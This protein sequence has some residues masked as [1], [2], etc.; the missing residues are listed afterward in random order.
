M[1]EK[2]RWMMIWCEV[3]NLHPGEKNHWE[4]AKHAY[5]EHKGDEEY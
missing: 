4:E 5:K 3:R 1:T 2:W